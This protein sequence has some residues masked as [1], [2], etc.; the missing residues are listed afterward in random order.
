MAAADWWT[1]ELLES[2]AAPRITSGTLRC[3]GTSPNKP[4][5][6]N[7]MALVIARPGVFFGARR[8][9]LRSRKTVGATDAKVSV[10]VGKAICPMRRPGPSNIGARSAA[11]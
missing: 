5:Q 3:S 8:A 7:A 1:I 9:F 10:T 4:R 11:S 2:P 6:M